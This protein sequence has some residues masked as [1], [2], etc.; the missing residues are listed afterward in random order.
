LFE[1]TAVSEGTLHAAFSNVLKVQQEEIRIIDSEN[2]NLALIAALTVANVDLLSCKPPLFHVTV[3]KIEKNVLHNA[4]NFHCS[5][6]FM[7][8][9]LDRQIT[10]TLGPIL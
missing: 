3:N 2:T 7:A 8:E 1:P 10:L 6:Q 5:S 9:N 4:Q